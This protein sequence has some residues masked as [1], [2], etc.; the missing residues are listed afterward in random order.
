MRHMKKKKLNSSINRIANMDL[1]KS[2]L[3]SKIHLLFFKASPQISVLINKATHLKN[4]IKKCGRNL[5]ENILCWKN[6]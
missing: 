5:T 4:I 2:F 1:I 3:I 6:T